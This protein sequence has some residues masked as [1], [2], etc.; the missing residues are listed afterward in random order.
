MDAVVFN[1]LL[2]ELGDTLSGARVNKVQQPS[3]EEL[4]LRLWNGRSEQLLYLRMSAQATCYLTERRFANPFTPPRFCQLLRARLSRLLSIETWQGE[5]FA[6]FRYNGKQGECLLL[7]DFRSRP[8]LILIDAHATVIDALHRDPTQN[9]LPGKEY[10]WPESRYLDLHDASLQPP[11]Q[12][13]A[14]QDWLCEQVAPMASSLARHLAH[15]VTS[16]R[17]AQAVLDRCR[18]QL[19]DEPVAAVQVKLQGR[20]QLLPFVPDGLA[21]EDILRRYRSLSEALEER[22]LAPESTRPDSLLQVVGKAIVKLQRRQKNIARDAAKLSTAPQIRQH[23]ELLLAQ[24]HLLQRGMCEV[25]LDDYYSSPPAKITLPL[26]AKLTPQENI[27]RLFKQVKKLQRG[28]E[29]VERRLAETAEELEWL[30][31]MQ[32]AIQECQDEV[33][34]DGLA[35]DLAAAG[36]LKLRQEPASRSRAKVREPLRRTTSPAGFELV[37]GKN[38]RGN[39]MVSCRLAHADDPWFHVHNQPGCHLIL[40]RAGQGGEIPAADIEYAAQLAAGYSAARKAPLVEVMLTTARSVSKPKGAR[41]G[42]VHV[43]TFE[44]IRVAPRRLPEDNGND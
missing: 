35:R 11:H 2:R 34:K 29:H 22:D 28:A 27:E 42:L 6:I 7:L 17:S 33:E 1:G 13:A 30:L 24:R 5:R 14:F 18:T 10:H 19:F 15:Q 38:P 9:I 4:V 3:A 20:A 39:D 41:P 16:E 32:L 43:A 44:T 12:A 25:E 26:E 23:A 8:N 36:Y 40:R 21:S 31:E 37:W